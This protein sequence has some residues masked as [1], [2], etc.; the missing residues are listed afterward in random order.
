MDDLG[1]LPK[2]HPRELATELAWADL[3]GWLI[4]WAV[5]HSL[6]RSEELML[7]TRICSEQAASRVRAERRRSG[8]GK[9]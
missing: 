1:P 6:T 9:G 3:Y 7:L 8:R 5:R 2:V 4:D